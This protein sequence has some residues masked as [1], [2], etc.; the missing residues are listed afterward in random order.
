MG[1]GHSDHDT[2]YQEFI[3][4]VT[5]LWDAWADDALVADRQTGVY[6][7]PQKLRSIDHGVSTGI[8]SKVSGSST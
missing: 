8:R 1:C 6:I 2:G 5:K 4:V 7:D 3:E